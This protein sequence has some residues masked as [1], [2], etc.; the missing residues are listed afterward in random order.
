MKAHERQLTFLILALAL[1][2]LLWS[3][4]DRIPFLKPFESS[5]IPQNEKQILGP[6]LWSRGA[7]LSWSA[8]QR[9]DFEAVPGL[10]AAQ[11]HRLIQWQQE[12]GIPKNWDQVLRV[13]GV[14]PKTVQRLQS[15][16]YLPNDPISK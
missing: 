7:K 1:G 16:F 3:K 14:G 12:Q 9:E 8:A 10:G 6:S 15:Y 2:A 5:V 13:P 4:S 11:I